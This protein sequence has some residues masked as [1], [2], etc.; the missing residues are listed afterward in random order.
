MGV[1]LDFCSTLVDLSLKLF[2]LSDHNRKYVAMKV[3]IGLD[4]RGVI[5]AFVAITDGKQSDISFART[6]ELP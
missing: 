4:H 6:L 1:H 5:P 3:H 2:P